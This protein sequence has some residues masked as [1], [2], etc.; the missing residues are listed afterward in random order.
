MSGLE[1]GAW[2]SLMAL[3]FPWHS[4]QRR[5]IKTTT[6]AVDLLMTTCDL[7]RTANVPLRFF[8]FLQSCTSSDFVWVIK[9][10]FFFITSR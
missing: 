8:P 5:L 6:A 1:G 3:S 7:F 2:K 10:F 9:D 4:V